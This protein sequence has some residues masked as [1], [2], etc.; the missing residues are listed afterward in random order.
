MEPDSKFSPFHKTSSFAVNIWVTEASQMY[1]KFNRLRVS[2]K[3]IRLREITLNI[4]ISLHSIA[5]ELLG[6]QVMRLKLYDNIA[7]DPQ[8]AW[9]G[10]ADLAIETL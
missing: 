3:V 5:F 9:V 7:Q 2:L 6:R 1:E 8:R 10:V 4:V